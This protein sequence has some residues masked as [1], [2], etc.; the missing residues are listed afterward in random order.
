MALP[1]KALIT[2][3]P[4]KAVQILKAANVEGIEALTPEQ[5]VEL[6]QALQVD[7]ANTAQQSEYRPA[8][9]GIDHRSR[10]FKDDF[11]NPLPDLK[12]VVI[13]YH[14]AR[15]HWAE[16]E[17]IPR[18]SS[19]DGVH[20]TMADATNG[21][22][23]LCATCVFNPTYTRNFGDKANCKE[24][25]RLFVLLEGDRYPV[26]LTLSP[27]SIGRWDNYTSALRRKGVALISAY[28][29]LRLESAEARGQTYAKILAELGPKLPA[30]A[31][32]QL[33]RMK[34]EVVK[35][36]TKLGIEEADYAKSDDEQATSGQT[37]AAGDGF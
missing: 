2:I 16:E 25:R 17:K 34:D 19:M 18:C 21:Q 7:Q 37:A 28:T 6:A 12:G 13:Y 36:A 1:E 10:K 8:R 31:V 3:D 20:G 24:L 33:A 26:L 30:P 27:T 29:V 5:Q 22:P 15:G 14:R 23:L 4:E 11:D 35:V 32:L 9:F